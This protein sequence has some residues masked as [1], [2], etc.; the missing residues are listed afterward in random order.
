MS[1]SDA[2]VY[3][4]IALYDTAPDSVSLE[5]IPGVLG[6]L[7]NR[8]SADQLP[9]GQVPDLESVLEIRCADTEGLDAAARRLEAAV[10]PP[11]AILR[12]RERTIMDRGVPEGAAKGVFLFRRREDL[13]LTDFQAY[14]LNHHGPIAAR[15][16]DALK[17]VQCHVLPESYQAGVPRYDGITEIYWPDFESMVPSMQS[18]EMTVDQAGDAKNFVAPGSV[19][20]LTVHE[21]RIG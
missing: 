3:R 19:D 15:T 7:L 16:P 18:P 14:W 13:A 5:G 12:T 17:Y 20:L 9:G 10:P 4:L 1:L 2:P 8:R 6:M 21:Q 11:V